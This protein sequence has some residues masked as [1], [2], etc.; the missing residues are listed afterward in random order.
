MTTRATPCT[1]SH[2]SLAL[3]PAS[4]L[5]VESVHQRQSR[6]TEH[7]P[8]TMALILD[9]LPL[10][11]FRS[12]SQPTVVPLHR[13]FHPSAVAEA[14]Q[15]RLRPRALIC[16]LL[17]NGGATAVGGSRIG[18]KSANAL[19]ADAGALGDRPFELIRVFEQFAGA[20]VGEFGEFAALAAECTLQVDGFA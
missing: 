20:L 1:A 14:R 19:A 10:A 12:A 6:R 2:S 3:A 11:A 5:D 17:L 18:A 4:T 9:P 15:E 13:T 16:S 7:H 8:L